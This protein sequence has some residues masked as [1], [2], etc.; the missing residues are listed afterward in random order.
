[1][2][3]ADYEKLTVKELKTK[4][5]DANVPKYY[6]LRKAELV[7]ALTGSRS[8]KSRS[9]SPARSRSKK[10]KIKFLEPWGKNSWLVEYDGPYK[11]SRKPHVEIGQGYMDTVK[12]GQV[13]TISDLHKEGR[14]IAW[15]VDGVEAWGKSPAH[16]TVAFGKD[17][18]IEDFM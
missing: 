12:R 9:K 3:R 6:Q 13:A 2:D 4:A 16:F 10:R 17:H 18:D 8:T 5:K 7:D 14:G 1:M 15:T 11:N